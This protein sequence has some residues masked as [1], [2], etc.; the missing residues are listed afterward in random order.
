MLPHNQED[1]MYWLDWRELEKQN[2]WGVRDKDDA[3]AALWNDSADRWEQRSAG[4][5]DFARRQVEALSISPSD[6]VIDVCCG[7]GPLTVFLCQRAARVTAFDFNE[8]MLDYVR[9]KA[10]KDHLENLDYIRGNFNTIRP[11]IDFEPAD[12]AVTRHSP[13]QGNIL[14]FSRFAKKYCYSLSL[15]YPAATDFP[16]PGRKGGFWCRSAKDTSESGERP[17]GRKFGLNI[18]FNL[19]YEAGADPEIFYIEDRQKI[20]GKSM[21]ELAAKY[22]PAAQT[23]EIL[24]YVKRHASSDGDMLFIERVQKMAVLGWDPGLIDP[25]L[26]P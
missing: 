20:E 15:I 21:E 16:L 5:T 8:K 3:T 26:I 2:D 24:E 13:A 19:L 14:K 18:S 6:H 9:E 22:F 12:I 10:A 7:T 23:P 17:D 11:G 4:E 1:K 25:S